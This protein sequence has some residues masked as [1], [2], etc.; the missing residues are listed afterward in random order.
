MPL[1]IAIPATH[2][3]EIHPR[4]APAVI[5]QVFTEPITKSRK[6]KVGCMLTVRFSTVGSTTLLMEKVK[7]RRNTNHVG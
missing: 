7:P 6:T 3:L 1:N 4:L 5:V 2:C